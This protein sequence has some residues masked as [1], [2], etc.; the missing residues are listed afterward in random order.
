MEA[1]DVLNALEGFIRA[2]WGT[3]V[4][5]AL[6]WSGLRHQLWRHRRALLHWGYELVVMAEY[7]F[8]PGGGPIKYAYVSAE[9]YKRLPKLL[10]IV[11]TKQEL[12]TLIE[13]SVDQLKTNLKALKT[14]EKEDQQ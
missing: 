6:T 10:K 5:A 11:I 4:A 13:A 14:N 3:A 1:N 9:I 12:D 7:I 8:G 2:F